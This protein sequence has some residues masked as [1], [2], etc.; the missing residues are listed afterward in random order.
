MFDFV[1][2]YKEYGIVRS[3]LKRDYEKNPL[4]N[5]IIGKNKDTGRFFKIKDA[6]NPYKDDLNYL[7]LECNCTR[8][9]LCQYFNISLRRFKKICKDLQIKKP[10]VLVQKNIEKAFINNYGVN[11]CWRDRT[12]LEKR[13]QT[14]LRLYD[15]ENVAKLPEIKEKRK[16]TCLKTFGKEY[17]MQTDDFKDKSKKTKLEKYGNETFVNS[18]KAKLTKLER[19]GNENYNNRELTEKTCLEKYNAKSPLNAECIKE[20]IKQTKLERYGNEN[21]N[22]WQKGIKTKIKNN[23]CNTSKD[24]EKIFNFLKTKF[25][26]IERQYKSEEYPWRC[27]FYLPEIDTYIEYQGH[28][29]HGKCHNK[30]Y[31][32]YNKNDKEHLLLLEEWNIKVIEGHE[33]YKTAIDVWTVR[34]PLKRETA[35]KNNLN[36]LEFFTMDEFLNWFNNI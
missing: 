3:K 14:N 20:Q 17:Y 28:F 19:Y 36:W 15:T 16:Q 34:D 7:Y 21:Y 13:K 18:D 2:F 24:E 12:V 23:T 6:E 25:N 35:K 5:T 27:D 1:S 26:K 30:I 9:S 33:Q 22:N 32:P 29:N 11:N 4:Q 10:K 31:G 8:E